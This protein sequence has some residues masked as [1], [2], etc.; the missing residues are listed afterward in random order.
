[1]TIKEELILY[2]N[3]CLEDKYINDYE[4]YISCKKHKQACKR[5]LNDLDRI[6]D[7]DFYYYWNEE[8]AEKIVKW[9]YYLRHSKGVLSGKPINLTIWQKFDLCQIYGWRHDTTGYKRFSKSF[10]EVARKNAKS[11]EEA[12]VVLYEIATQSTKNNEVYEAYCAGVKREQSKVIFDECGLMLKGSPLATKFNITK[13]LITH[14]KT[15]SYLK[16]LCKED[17]KKGD[18]TNPAILV[19]DEY[20]QHPTTEFYDLGYGSNTKESLLMVITTAGVDLNFPCYVQEYKYCSNVLNPSVDVFNDNYF[21]DILELDEDDNIEDVRNWRKSN[22]IRMTFAEGVK[23]ITDDYKIAKE[24]PEKMPKFMTKCLNVWM[25][26]KENGYMNMVKWK[27]CEVKKIEYCLKGKSCFIG[28]DMS[29]K[30]DLTSLSFVIP[31]MDNGVK[32]YIVFSHSFIPNYEKLRERILKDKMP[33]DSWVEQEYITVTN[34]PIIDQQQVIDYARDFCKKNGWGIDTWCFDPA[35]ASKIMM[36]LANEGENVVELFQSHLKLNESTCALRE[37]VYLGNIIYLPDPVL[38]FAMTNTILK[39]NNGMIKIDK[40]ATIQRIDPIDALI[41]AFK[42]AY[43]EELQIDI[44][45]II[46]AGWKM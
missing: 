20:H 25:Q 19:I 27:A 9:F 8:E 46:K 21:I 29:A 23:K 34:T 22:P 16:A 4:D 43:L 45:K 11:Q 39:V 13:S 41:C 42:M 35:N 2:C 26:A 17:G 1:M 6:G 18:G 15:G 30:I 5:F 44:N 14:I 38:N 3:N 31:I 33:Y 12:G 32:K 10:I 40:D 37:Q 7:I 24:I 36:D 28:G